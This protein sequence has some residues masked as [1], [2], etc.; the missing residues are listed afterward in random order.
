MSKLLDW[1]SGWPKT[2]A[3]GTNYVGG[4]LTMDHVDVL[5]SAIDAN[6]GEFVYWQA[7]KRKDRKENQPAVDFCL[8]VPEELPDPQAPAAEDE[9]GLPF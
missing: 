4:K 6:G 9:E 3:K 7:F 8:S 2:S 5:R 1:F